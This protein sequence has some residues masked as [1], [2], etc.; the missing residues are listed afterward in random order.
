MPKLTFNAKLQVGEV[1]FERLLND[2]SAVADHVTVDAAKDTAKFEGKSDSG[3][4]T[5]SL[6]KGSEGLL[7]LEVKDTSR[8]TYATSYLLNLAKAAGS[9]TDVV[10]FEY[11]SKMPLKLEY[12]LGQ[13]GGR[14]HF[15]LAPRIEER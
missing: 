13:G 1:F 7:V 14:I 6:E 12:K 15:Y 3:S 10:T 2:V 11:S 9:A 5:A 4:V 8:A